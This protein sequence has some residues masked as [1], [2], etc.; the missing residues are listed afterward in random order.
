MKKLIHLLTSSN[1]WLK[2]IS[3]PTRFQRGPLRNCWFV[4]AGAFALAFMWSTSVHAG[5]TTMYRYAPKKADLCSPDLLQL[6]VKDGSLKGFTYQQLLD[7]L[8]TANSLDTATA[9]DTPKGYR[10]AKIYDALEKLRDEQKAAQKLARKTP[11][12]RGNLG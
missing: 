3:A 1:L 10:S 11:R 5:G 12:C 4:T 9:K 6:K 7:Q 8:H 2:A